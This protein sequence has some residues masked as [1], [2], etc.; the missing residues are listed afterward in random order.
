MAGRGNF[1]DRE[2][3]SSGGDYIHQ[4]NQTNQVN[5]QNSQ[6]SPPNRSSPPS[7]HLHSSNPQTA[8]WPEEEEE[9]EEEEDRLDHE[10]TMTIVR[11]H[12]VAVM[13]TVA[14]GSRRVRLPNSHIQ[15]ISEFEEPFNMCLDIERQ[16]DHEDQLDF[17]HAM[18]I[19]RDHLIAVI[20]TIARGAS[21]ARLTNLH[22]QFISEHEEQFNMYLDIERKL[23]QHEEQLKQPEHRLDYEHAMRIVWDH[24]AVMINTIAIGLRRVRL[25]NWHIQFISPHE[26]P[27]NMYL[28]IEHQL[29]RHESH[30]SLYD[31]H[32]P[33]VCN[34]PSGLRPWWRGGYA[35]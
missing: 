25:T 27:F 18:V 26:E 11:N 29:D 7:L 14:G 4:I 10:I 8:N 35:T 3:S 5:S 24:H 21:R 20:N 31:G 2:T 34:T 15:F 22:I 28:N 30:C 33:N 13:N 16:L 9:E 12:Q 17:E 32:G 19:V 1:S 23:D 6:N